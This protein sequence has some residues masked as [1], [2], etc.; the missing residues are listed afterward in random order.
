MFAGKRYL[1]CLSSSIVIMVI[2]AFFDE[3]IRY[4][5]QVFTWED[6]LKNG[7]ERFGPNLKNWMIQCLLCDQSYHIDPDKDEDIISQASQCPNCESSTAN[8]LFTNHIIILQ[9]E[10]NYIFPFTKKKTLLAR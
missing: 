6:W 5:Y 4:V 3:I 9:S 8:G 7:T 1:Y 2:R 10:I